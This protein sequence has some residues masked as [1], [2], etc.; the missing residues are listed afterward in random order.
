MQKTPPSIMQSSAA[1]LPL[2]LFSIL[3]GGAGIAAAAYSPVQQLSCSMD[4]T[5]AIFQNERI[6]CWGNNLRWGWD[7]AG[8][9]G[10]GETSDSR[11]TLPG[12][13]GE[14]LPFVDLGT[15]SISGNPLHV[16]GMSGTYW[17]T[18]AILVG[19]SGS[20]NRRVKCWGLNVQGSLGLGDL[21]H[22]GGSPSDMGNSL[23]FVD[24]GTDG[25]SQWAVGQVSVA[26][27]ACALLKNGGKIKCWGENFLGQLGLGD[28]MARG[29]EPGEMGDSL[30]FVDLGTSGGAKHLCTG[31]SHTCAVLSNGGRIKCWGYNGESSLGLGDTNDRGSTEGTMGDNLPF[32]DLGTDANGQPL[33]ATQVEC[34]QYHTCALMA[35]GRVKCWGMND[36]GQLGLG[37]TLSRGGDASHMGNSL[38]YVD[39]GTGA[40]NTVVNIS[41]SGAGACVLLQ[42]ARIKCWGYWNSVS[43][44]SSPGE[45]GD[46]LPYISLSSGYPGVGSSGVCQGGDASC[47]ILL[48]ANADVKCWG[49]NGQGALGQGNTA[50]AWS[51]ESLDPIRLQEQAPPPASP[52]PPPPPLPQAAG[53]EYRLSHALLPAC[54]NQMKNYICLP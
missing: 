4:R 48:D 53:C 34:G 19:D 44:G 30:P 26:N 49:W 1:P 33:A 13:M 20:I 23:P 16:V 28:T 42:N 9:L 31:S 6:K 54:L 17:T 52:P 37:D 40:G 35:D 12:D 45:M 29:D 27:H 18:C 32:V 21:M 51:P 41:L 24:L 15:D 22:R 10:L 46:N 3:V 39:L 25:G 5:C 7:F 14:N 43:L 11:G 2:L 8:L 47:A 50:D 36:G 38:P